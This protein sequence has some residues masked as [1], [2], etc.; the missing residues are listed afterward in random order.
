MASKHTRGSWT[1]R[2]TVEVWQDV[3]PGLSKRMALARDAKSARLIAA[4]PE[5]LKA[6]KRLLSDTDTSNRWL[7]DNNA[8]SKMLESLADEARAVIAKAEDE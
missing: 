2:E 1:V 8:G 6:L 7:A 4:A 3:T 5:L